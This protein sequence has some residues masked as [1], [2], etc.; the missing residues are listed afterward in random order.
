MVAEPT[1]FIQDWFHPRLW[2]KPNA[3][4]MYSNRPLFSSCLVLELHTASCPGTTLM[5]RSRSQV[6]ALPPYSYSAVQFPSGTPSWGPFHLDWESLRSWAPPQPPGT[7]ALRGLPEAC[8]SL[9][10]CLR[11]ASV[12]GTH[13]PAWW[14]Q[15]AATVGSP[16]AGHW[17]REREIPTICPCSGILLDFC[18]IQ[19]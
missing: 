16:Q 12:N 3:Q 2:D 1:G 9:G 7:A 14:G 8:A 5:L 6:L 10:P 4:V 17:R 13:L 15:H 19:T 18:M 11:P